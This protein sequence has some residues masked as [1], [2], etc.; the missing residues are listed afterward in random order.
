[1]ENLRYIIVSA[2]YDATLLLFRS[3]R[4]AL[5]NNKKCLPKST[6]GKVVICWVKSGYFFEKI[7]DE[8]GKIVLMSIIVFLMWCWILANP[9]YEFFQHL[10]T[11]WRENSLPLKKNLRKWHIS[12]L[13]IKHLS[14]VSQIWI[15]FEC[16]FMCYFQR[17]MLTSGRMD[18]WTDIRTYGRTGGQTYII[19]FL[20]LS[21]NKQELCY[22]SAKKT[23]EI[24]YCENDTRL[25]WNK[26]LLR[27]ILAYILCILVS[28]T[29][30]QDEQLKYI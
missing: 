3:L 13:L 5:S 25:F 7:D 23:Y 1:M 8:K 11:F 4:D 9:I 30:K 26:H 15:D 24:N 6:P 29:Y 14:L 18:E 21:I 10:Y 22:N 27:Y 19:L 17:N 12:S 28:G 20:L 2:L 16:E